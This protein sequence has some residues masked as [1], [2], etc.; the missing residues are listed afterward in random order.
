MVGHVFLGV[1][2]FNGNFGTHVFELHISIG[3]L[4]FPKCRIEFKER[5]RARAV[6]LQQ[7]TVTVA[8][9]I[10]AI[11]EAVGWTLLIVGIFCRD[12]LMTGH[13]PVAVARNRAAGARLLLEKHGCDFL[14]MDDGFQSA[15]IHIDY[16]LLVIDARY[17]LGNG[18]HKDWVHHTPIHLFS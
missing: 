18:P 16:A 3:V 9:K 13:A 7:R 10:A 5:I 6:A 14:I 12:V 17:G 2:A 11:A 4:D 1:G 15:H 8:D